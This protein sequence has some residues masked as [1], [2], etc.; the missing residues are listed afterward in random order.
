MRAWRETSASTSRIAHFKPFK[1][2]GWTKRPFDPWVMISDTPRHSWKLQEGLGH[3]LEQSQ[4]TAFSKWWQYEH[5]CHRIIIEKR[6]SWKSFKGDNWM[7]TEIISPLGR[8]FAPL[9]G[10]LPL[11]RVWDFR[12]REWEIFYPKQKG[13]YVCFSCLAFPLKRT[14]L[15]ATINPSFIRK[16]FLPLHFLLWRRHYWERISLSRLIPLACS[17]FV[18]SLPY[19]YHLL[20]FRK[21]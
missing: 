18:N 17:R 19:T 20:K 15:S 21:R 7:N 4:W 12:H 16:S 6:Y 10:H 2:L 3:G 11:L 9:A 14:I 5:I 8:K 13:C 1:S